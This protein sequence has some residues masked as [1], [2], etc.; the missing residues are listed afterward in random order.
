VPALEGTYPGEKLRFRFR[1]SAVGIF[2]AAGPDAGIVEYSIDGSPS[3]TKDLYTR[4]SGRLHLPWAHVL[5]TGLD[6]SREH[7][8]EL[9]V[10]KQHNPA[11]SGRK[12]RIFHFLVN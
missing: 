4:W 8:L 3:K 12:V 1:G 9:S 6:S 7:L 5:E 10:L 2:V 11:S